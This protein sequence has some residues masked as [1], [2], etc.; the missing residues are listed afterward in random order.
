MRFARSVQV[1]EVLGSLAVLAACLAVLRWGVGFYQREVLPSVPQPTVQPT[2]IPPRLDEQQ[3]LR[4]QRAMEFLGA[5]HAFRQANQLELAR[6]HYQ[7]ALALDPENAEAQ[8][9]LRAVEAQL[10]AQS[11]ATPTPARRD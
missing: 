7:Q 6:R 11:T 9:A 8:A 1:W 4:V 5:G 10:Q 3:A 2:R